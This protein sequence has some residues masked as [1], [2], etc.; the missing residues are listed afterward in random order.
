MHCYKRSWW[1]VGELS[2]VL[3]FFACIVLSW[4]YNLNH[5]LTGWNLCCL[6]S[7]KTA[8]L[9][10]VQRSII[11]INTHSIMAAR[12]HFP[13]EASGGVCILPGDRFLNM[14]WTVAIPLSIRLGTC[15]VHVDYT[16]CQGVVSWVIAPLFVCYGC[17]TDILCGNFYYFDHHYV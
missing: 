7:R 2:I 14:K 15:N 3:L 4:L 6:E 16:Q 8:Q 12:V 13:L 5:L 1:T 10:C 11:S 9:S 17:F